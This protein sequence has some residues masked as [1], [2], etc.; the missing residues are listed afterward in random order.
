[1]IH[2]EDKGEGGRFDHSRRP[3]AVL[4]TRA[5]QTLRDCR[6]SSDFAKRLEFRIR[7]TL[8]RGSDVKRPGFRLPQRPESPA[9][10]DY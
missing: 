9:H 10:L 7:Q 5:L 1:V 8:A 4:K 3:K 6:A 2:G